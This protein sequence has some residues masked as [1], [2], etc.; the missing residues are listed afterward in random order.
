M[1]YNFDF[2]VIEKFLCEFLQT[3]VISYEDWRFWAVPKVCSCDSMW[4][5]FCR[6]SMVGVLAKNFLSYEVWQQAILVGLG[7]KTSSA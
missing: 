1:V 5:S 7:Y 6:Y 2:T 4:P 3:T